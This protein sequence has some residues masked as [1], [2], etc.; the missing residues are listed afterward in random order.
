MNKINKDTINYYDVNAEK[1]FSSTVNAEMSRIYDSFLKYVPTNGHILDFG[2]G[3]GR[4]SKHFLDNGYKVTAIDGSENLCRLA[5][6][7]TG[8]PVKHMYF[9]ELS[10]INLYDGIWACSSIIHLPYD[11]LVVVIPKMVL[12]L[13]ENGVIYT[14]FKNGDGNELVD[15]KYF[16]YLTKEGFTDL[17]A[18]YKELELLDYYDSRSVSNPNETKYWNNFVLRKTKKL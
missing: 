5:T 8:I 15:G 11:E 16:T 10:D 18:N 13:K 12:A 2:C 14:C 1:Y 4:D 17:I 7:Y 3:S 6:D 9:S